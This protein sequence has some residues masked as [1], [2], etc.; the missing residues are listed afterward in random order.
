M[1]EHACGEYEWNGNAGE[2]NGMGM[3]VDRVV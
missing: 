2:W 3:R 1:C